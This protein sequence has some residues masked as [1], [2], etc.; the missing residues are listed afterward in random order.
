MKNFIFCL[1]ISFSLLG[2]AKAEIKCLQ[3]L[4]GI[5]TRVLVRSD[6]AKIQKIIHTV[7]RKRIRKA[8]ES[9]EFL[10]NKPKVYVLRRSKDLF[11]FLENTEIQGDLLE[12]QDMTKILWRAINEGSEISSWIKKLQ[13]ELY[14]E[15]YNH[16]PFKE[17]LLLKTD[18]RISQRVIIDLMIK[19]YIQTELFSGIKEVDRALTDDNF[20]HLLLTKKLI[21]DNA[22]KGDRHGHLTHLLQVDMM[23]DIL[24]NHGYQEAQIVDFYKWMGNSSTIRDSMHKEVVNPLSTVWSQLFDSFE[25]NL[26]SPEQINPIFMYAFGLL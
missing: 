3:K 18:G 6:E 12:K 15:A 26:A 13:A 4:K 22:F 8:K 9:I 23:F 19:K 16:S 10:A 11:R 5:F 20:G 14:T 1:L 7:G 25:T 24:K 21:I 2:S 17:R